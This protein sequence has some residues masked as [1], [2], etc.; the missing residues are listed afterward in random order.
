MKEILAKRLGNLLSVKSIVTIVLTFV[1]SYL[2]IRQEIS[3]DMMTVYMVIIAFYF[4]TQAEK[5]TQQQ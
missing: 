2:A 3:Q 1:F 4:S 5:N